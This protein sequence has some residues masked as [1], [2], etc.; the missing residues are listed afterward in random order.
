MVSQISINELLEGV[1]KLSAED[2]DLFFKKITKLR[3]EKEFD[4]LD[5]REAKLLRQIKAELPRDLAQRYALLIA[6]RDIRTLTDAEYEELLELTE[7][8]EEHQ[9]IRLR[10]IA[11]LAELKGLSLS[12]TVSLYKLRPKANV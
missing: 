4:G 11:S 10:H 6:K 8:V 2:F 1:Q 7:K 12:E 9:T 3:S 5:A